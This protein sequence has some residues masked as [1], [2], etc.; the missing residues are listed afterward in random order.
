MQHRTLPQELWSPFQ[1]HPTLQRVMVTLGAA[2]LESVLEARK[3]HT[4]SAYRRLEFLLLRARMRHSVHVNLEGEAPGVLAACLW[5]FMAN[6]PFPAIRN[7]RDWLHI[8]A[9]EFN[10]LFE[11]PTL[12]HLQKMYTTALLFLGRSVRLLVVSLLFMVRQQV[13]AE[14]RRGALSLNEIDHLLKLTFFYYLKALHWTGSRSCRARVCRVFVNMV[15]NTWL[16]EPAFTMRAAT[17]E[18]L[19]TCAG[20]EGVAWQ[21]VVTSRLQH[22][23]WYAA[24]RRWDL[25]RRDSEE[26]AKRFWSLDDVL[27]LD[28]PGWLGWLPYCTLFR[29]LRCG[30]GG[31]TKTRGKKTSPERQEDAVNPEEGFL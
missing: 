14:L 25:A 20:S 26:E 31:A 18:V 28:R 1:L 27:P 12:S 3:I 6:L 22:Y 21:L 7:E 29:L 17:H 4:V 10:P 9:Y 2:G 23:A 13:D 8:Y 24:D 30:R 11:R 5:D 16:L 19:T 15:R